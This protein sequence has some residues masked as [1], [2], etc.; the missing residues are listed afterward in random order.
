MSSQQKN[1]FDTE[2]SPW[3]VDARELQLV[4]TVILGE[5]PHGEYDYL[6]PDEFA[7][8]DRTDRLVEPGRRVQV[9][10]GRSNRLVVAY[11]VH[12]ETKSVDTSR[13][14]KVASVIDTS[15]LLSPEMLRIT[16]WMSEYYLCP[17]GQVLE[18]VVPA[19]VRHQAGTREVQLLHVPE[20]V[21]HE[22][23]KLKLPPKQRHALEILIK[24]NPL[25]PAKLAEAAGCTTAPIRQLLK[26]GLVQSE[27]RRISTSQLDET[28]VE[29]VAPLA[30]NADQQ[31]ALDRIL[32]ALEQG[33]PHGMVLH[34]V[35]GSGKTEVYLHAIDRVVSFGRQAI[36]LV[37]EISLTPQTVRRFR[38]RFDSVA[39]LHS[40]QTAVERHAQWQRIANGEVQVVV[41]ARSAVFAPTP[42]LGLIVIDEEHETS[43]KQDTAPRYHAR[44]VAWQRALSEKIP[45]V[46]GSATPSL[47]AWHRAEAGNFEHISMPRRVSDRRMPDVVTVDLRDRALS[48]GGRGG[49]SRPLMQAMTAALQDEGQVILFLNRRAFLHTFNVPRVGSYFSAPIASSHSRFIVNKVK[50]S[51]TIAIISNRRPPIAPI[52]SHTRS[53]MGDLAHKSW[54]TKCERDFQSTFVPAW[55]PTVCELAAAINKCSMPLVEVR[56]IFCS[57]LK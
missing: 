33:E 24:H 41:G 53:V 20:D 35:T 34:G 39:V 44:E 4:A 54:K 49:I 56:L 52:A 38:A 23:P 19:G 16:R 28:K 12:L 26:K 45:L 55:I 8:T 25:T 6:V 27:T 32:A 10:F 31:Q 50:Q 9:P 46:L 30:L 29:R 48:R 51:V 17:W 22:L 5:G 57:V 43:F 3:E 7:N 14:K 37:P 18:A 15:T 2:P 1:L 42:H 21:F 47:E 13:L 40:H 36:I 11:C